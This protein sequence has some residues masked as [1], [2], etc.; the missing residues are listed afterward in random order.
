MENTWCFLHITVG[1]RHIKMGL[2]N[3][4]VELKPEHELDTRDNKNYKVEEIHD[5]NIHTKEIIS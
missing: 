1:A 5:S 4:L 2:V 3:E